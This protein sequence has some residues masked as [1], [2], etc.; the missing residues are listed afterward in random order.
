MRDR[1]YCTTWH[2]WLLHQIV[3]S[4][5]SHVSLEINLILGNLC[6]NF[7]QPL[8]S[9]FEIVLNLGVGRHPSLIYIVK[10]ITLGPV[11]HQNL[12][13]TRKPSYCS[14]SA[15]ATPK[16]FQLIE[17][18][19][20]DCN[21]TWRSWMFIYLKCFDLNWRQIMKMSHCRPILSEQLLQNSGRQKWTF[22]R[23]SKVWVR[24]F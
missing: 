6:K 3:F 18:K 23:K 11:D 7:I 5:M 12:M 8:L 16:S 24:K 19:F 2:H 9:L 22:I 13:V 10:H 1:L 15:V 20:V 17:H 14:I 4:I 21:F